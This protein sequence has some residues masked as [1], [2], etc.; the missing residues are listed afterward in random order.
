MFRQSRKL[1]L[2]ATVFAMTVAS[3]ASYADYEDHHKDREDR[4]DGE[5]VAI[6]LG[7]NPVPDHDDPEAQEAACVALQLGMNLLSPI[8]P[9][10]T[11]TPTAVEPADRVVLFPTLGGVELINPHNDLDN[12]LCKTP[13]EQ[14]LEDTPLAHVL[15]GFVAAGGEIIVCP[16]CAYARNIVEP[17]YGTMG[18]GVSIH[19]LFID[20]DKV[21]SF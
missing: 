17:S 16:L 7:T 9:D 8:V 11:N 6:T 1:V 20:A 10:S 15:A 4:D 5:Y 19:E 2:A 12:V 21:L 3:S 13:G 18:S 14:G